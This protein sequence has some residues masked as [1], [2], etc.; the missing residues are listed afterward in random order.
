MPPSHTFFS[1]H[2][3]NNLLHY[4]ALLWKSNLEL[5]LKNFFPLLSLFLSQQAKPLSELKPKDL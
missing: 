5:K 2:I 3:T 1:F 4:K